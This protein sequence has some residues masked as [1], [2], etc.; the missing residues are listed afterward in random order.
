MSSISKKD[1]PLTVSAIATTAPTHHAARFEQT[2]RYAAIII[3]A[4][5]FVAAPAFNGT[6]LWDDDQEIT[7]N[8]ALRTLGGLWAIWSGNAG[9]DYLPLKSTMLWLQYH[10]WE[11]NNTGYHL[12]TVLFHT[13]NALLV[14]KLF[15]KLG[16]KAAWLGGLL[17][18]VH[19]VLVESVA[20]VSEQKNTLSLALLLPSMLWWLDFDEQ[21]RAHRPEAAL[22]SCLWSLLFFTGSL[23]CKSSGIMLPLAFLLYA[24][25][26]YSN[27]A[28]KDL[29]CFAALG[30]GAAAFLGLTLIAEREYFEQPIGATPA[31]L[32]LGGAVVC[33]L[34]ALAW[35]RC[36]RADSD[37]G[38]AYAA[39]ASIP[40][41]MVVVII[42]V[43]TIHFQFK[44]AI[45][46]EWI[47]VGDYLSRTACAG[48]LVWFYLYC[49]I[50]PFDLC[51]I[52]PK[53]NVDPPD[54][55]LFL[56]WPLLAALLVWLW[57]KRHT[58][59]RHVLLGLGFFLIFLVPV[60]GF[61]TMSYMR[62]TWAAD[63]FLYIPAI[64]LIALAVA[65]VEKLYTATPPQYKQ[66]TLAGLIVLGCVLTG[67]AHRYSGIFANEAAMWTYT[68]SKNENAWQAHSRY[69]KVL[70]DSGNID[71]AW[72][73]IFHSNRLRPD[74]AETNNN[75]GVLLM[76]K[77]RP[78]EAVPYMQKAASIMPEAIPFRLNLANLL[79]NTG[80]ARESL[81][82]YEYCLSRDP[83]NPVF[84]T[85]YGF[86][87]YLDGQRDRAIAEFRTALQI[88]PNFANAKKNLDMALNNA[89]PPTTPTQTQPSAGN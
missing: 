9:A 81:P 54:W 26:R 12:V 47:P 62:I 66:A 86:A 84:H 32:L 31:A 57:T 11:Q 89:K 45:G 83:R 53:W 10:L 21:R 58:W 76:Q 29:L 13:I 17:F 51:P 67:Y 78:Q 59:G 19:P 3:L 68:L 18:A 55:Y 48:M 41:L 22:W 46:S 56:L 28:L 20:W 34:L 65:V 2:W 70:L 5:L 36:K 40:F 49:T 69:G 80:H 4:S 75:M 25:Y 74:L 43:I 77:N 1:R 60:L 14:W 23:L 38:I 71:A 82:H 52:Y 16:L 73:H 50:F 24:W 35:R 27:F 39:L 72:V 8:G 44:N 42:S 64:G 30:A 15:H 7:A 61:V 87:L 37:A 63:H 6:W 88:D 79:A 85:N 33:P